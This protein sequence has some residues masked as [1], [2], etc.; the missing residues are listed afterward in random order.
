M[1]VVGNTKET[2]CMVISL[3]VICSRV[4]V[5]MREKDGDGCDKTWQMQIRKRIEKNPR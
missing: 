4:I 2:S 1:N 3:R 5:S